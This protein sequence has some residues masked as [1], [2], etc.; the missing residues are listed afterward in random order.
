MTGFV[1]SSALRCARID[2]DE[3]E[4]RVFERDD[5]P[6]GIV[7]G[8]AEIILHGERRVFGEDRR[9]GIALLLRRAP[10]LLI[11]RK[12]QLDL[13]GLQLRLL[14]AEKVGVLR[15]ENVLEAFFYAGSESVDVPREKSHFVSSVFTATTR[16][17]VTPSAW[18]LAS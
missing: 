8:N 17:I 1:S 11:A 15:M 7:L 16:L 6:L 13:A 2:R 10:E 3:P 5:A 12:V 9:A 18:N 4:V 14:Q